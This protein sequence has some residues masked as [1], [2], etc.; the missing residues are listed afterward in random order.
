[1][2]TSTV[3]KKVS[4][5]NTGRI[6]KLSGVVKSVNQY[7]PPPFIEGTFSTIFDI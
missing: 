4:D 1:M 7:T 3:A 5:V 2:Q 6:N